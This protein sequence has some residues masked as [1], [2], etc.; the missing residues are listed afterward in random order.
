M[1]NNITEGNATRNGSYTRE[2]IMKIK[3]KHKS[4]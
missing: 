4:G 1:K 2:E 3:M